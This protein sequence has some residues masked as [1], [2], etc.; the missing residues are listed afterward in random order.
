MRD[1]EGLMSHGLPESSPRLAGRAG[2]AGQ[3]GQEIVAKGWTTTCG[4]SH[5]VICHILYVCHTTVH[6]SS[7]SVAP[8]YCTLY[9]RTVDDVCIHHI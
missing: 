5:H 7:S 6:M 9:Y 1:V 2:Q 8:T 4:M 3:A